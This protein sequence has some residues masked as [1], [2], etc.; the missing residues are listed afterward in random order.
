MDGLIISRVI[1]F[2]VVI[3]HAFL[4]YGGP[5][6]FTK[7][8]NAR[9]YDALFTVEI[10]ALTSYIVYDNV[11]SPPEDGWTLAI[12]G[13][14]I[15]YAFVV[16]S[17]LAFAPLTIDP[18]KVYQLTEVEHNNRKVRIFDKGNIEI[19]EFEI[20][21]GTIREGWRKFAVTLVDEEGD[22]ASDGEEQIYVRLKSVQRDGT[23]LVSRFKNTNEFKGMSSC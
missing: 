22:L 6:V 9:L 1:L 13:Y 15:V 3:I 5:A 19:H 18:K 14:I 4:G 17:W 16:L 7:H 21:E 8:V 11:L 20:V 2:A 10:L 23:I 12:I